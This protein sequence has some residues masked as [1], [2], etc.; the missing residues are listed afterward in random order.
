MSEQTKSPEQEVELN[1]EFEQMQ[2]DVDAAVEAAEQVE[3]EEMS[4]EAEIALL[5]SELEAAKQTINDQKDSVV[6][7]A[8]DV[9]NMRRRAAQDV[10]KAHKFALEKFANELLPVIDNL[11]RAIEFS[12]KENEQ[13]KPV[14]EGIEMTVKSFND[15]VSK[16]GVEIVNPQGE[17]FNP[18]FHQAM[19]IQPSNDVAPNTVLAV[20]QKGYTLNGRLLRPAMV[21]VSKEAE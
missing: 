2:A 21:M 15:A 14:L 17:Q 12:D 5:H 11:E 4:P 13:L 7:A 19:S 18:E 3:G 16:F 9:E 8:A 20:M 10:E 6:R 1:E